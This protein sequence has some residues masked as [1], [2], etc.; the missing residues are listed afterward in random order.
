MSTRGAAKRK[1]TAS[2]AHSEPKPKAARRGAKSRRARSVATR[3]G[4]D[5]DDGGS[6]ADA[7]EQDSIERAFWEAFDT[8][9][10]LAWWLDYEGNELYLSAEL[11][12]DRDA[13]ISAL[14]Q[15]RADRPNPGPGSSDLLELQINWRNAHP[16]AAGAACPGWHAASPAAPQVLALQQLQ[17]IHHAAGGPPPASAAAAQPVPSPQRAP[18]AHAAARQLTWSPDEKYPVPQARSSCATCLVR[19]DPSVVNENRE[20]L[21]VCGRRGDLPGDG[22][23]NKGLMEERRRMQESQQAAELRVWEA[24]RPAPSAAAAGQHHGTTKDPSSSSA[25][26]GLTALERKFRQLLLASKESYPVFDD[27][28]PLTGQSALQVSRKAF[29]ATAYD[30]P[31]KLLVELIRA[32]LLTQ[33]GYAIPLATGRDRSQEMAIGSILLTETNGLAP[34]GKLSATQAPPVTSLHDFCSA[35]FGTILP[36]LID[37]PAAMM[38]WITLGRTALALAP[39]PARWPA[40]NAYIEQLLAERVPQRLNLAD[41]S[42]PVLRTV[43]F[44]FPAHAQNAGGA[45]PHTSGNNGGAGGAGG[46]RVRT[47]NGFN[48]G[49]R[50]SSQPCQFAHQCEGCGATGHGKVDCT[51][52][53]A[54]GSGGGRGG[55]GGGRG[56]SSH[57]G[58][59][60][61]GGGANPPA[62]AAKREA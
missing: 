38:E 52:R 60:G 35:M 49:G 58:G 48:N 30:Q 40:A 23:V 4:D 55:R 31:P 39:T 16:Q 8:G 61:A 27:A 28:A 59:G 47:C 46:A 6:A 22:A 54:G 50:C 12:S 13:V 18:A 24:G 29:T 57:R 42:D 43:T 37:R 26:D 36:A 32:G 41:V 7:V 15:R 9:L 56:G 44:A 25:T 2:V 11:H 5:E 34:Q 62:A 21:C 51:R 20:W 19:P 17:T 33:V 45:P 10:L 14:V 3:D 1:E 53:S